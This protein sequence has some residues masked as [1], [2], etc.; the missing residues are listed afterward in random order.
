MEGLSED[1][2]SSQGDG[3]GKCYWEG[4]QLVRRAMR[5]RKSGLTSV[6]IIGILDKWNM[7]AHLS[8]LH[9]SLQ[10]PEREGEQ[11]SSC[12]P[13]PYPPTLHV[14]DRRNLLSQT[15]SLCFSIWIRPLPCF[16][17]HLT[18][19]NSFHAP[20]NTICVE[21]PTLSYNIGHLRLVL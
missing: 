18:F 16:T 12:P 7:T 2:R 19:K 20:F 11:I 17:Y 4:E 1:I 5:K 13:P 10:L 15:A 21:N 3:E 6:A 14:S 9:S 8:Q